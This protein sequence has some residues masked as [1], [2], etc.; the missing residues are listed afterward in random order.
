MTEP[1]QT[2]GKGKIKPRWVKGQSGNPKG[3]PKTPPTMKE[4]AEALPDLPALFAKVLS[5]KKGD[6]TAIEAGLRRTLSSW[7]NSGNLQAGRL[8]LEYAYGKPNE[9]DNSKAIENQ[10]PPSIHVHIGNDVVK[11]AENL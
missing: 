3:K 8:I 5:E 4:M 7:I 6:M 2:G 1:K 10:P 9:Y 11:K